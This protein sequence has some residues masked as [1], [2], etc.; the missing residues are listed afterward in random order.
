M[1]IKL[2]IF[3]MDGLMFDTEKIYFRAWSKI[4]SQ[5]NYKF[6]FEVYKKL[7]ARNSHD[8]EIILKGLYGNEF[9]FEEINQKRRKEADE[10][11]EF[12]GI[13]HKKGLTNLLDFLDQNQIK[14]IVATSSAREKALRYL[15]KADV[16]DRFDNIVCGSDVTK[17]KPNPEIFEKAAEVYKTRK[18][19]CIVLE[20][21][22]NGVRAAYNGNMKCIFIPD[23]VQA[24]DEIKQK[25]TIELSS[26]NDVV[27]YVKNYGI[28]I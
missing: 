21:S 9:E 15:K 8:M 22:E 4:M 24:T 2:V 10:I 16:L 5:Y 14:K 20:D 27:D 12:E 25:I 23:L 26:L 11:I 1:E 3:D 18:E 28:N 19:N 13:N 17:S 7:M 6:D